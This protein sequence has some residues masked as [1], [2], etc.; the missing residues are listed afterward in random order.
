MFL[1]TKYCYYAFTFKSTKHCF[2][3]H[4]VLHSCYYCIKVRLKI[5]FF[6]W[7]QCTCFQYISAAVFC[8][9]CFFYT[10]VTIPWRAAVSLSWTS[11]LTL[12][13]EDR[14]N[15][16]ISDVILPSLDAFIL[17]QIVVFFKQFNKLLL[18]GADTSLM[19]CLHVIC[20]LLTNILPKNGWWRMIFVLPV[21]SRNIQECF[22]QAAV[23]GCTS[24]SMTA[25]EKWRLAV[26]LG[27]T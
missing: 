20:F 11:K 2:Y 4:V 23:A 1:G 14:D 16:N 6:I 26:S 17:M 21:C 12:A 7:I 24:S 19:H 9:V 13:K 25:L 8:S 3:F 18:W 10:V 5:R 27:S 15:G 22:S